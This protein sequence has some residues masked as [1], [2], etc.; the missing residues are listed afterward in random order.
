MT[1]GTRTN[2][3][4]GAGT[5]RGRRTPKR[6]FPFLAA[7][8]SVGW[9]VDVMLE[10]P[11]RREIVVLASSDSDCRPTVAD[12]NWSSSRKA[13]I[14]ETG[15]VSRRI[16]AQPVVDICLGL[17]FER[18]K[19]WRCRIRNC[20]FRQR[21]GGGLRASSHFISVGYDCCDRAE[22]VYQ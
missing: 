7:I 14:R 13:E 8:N 10:D 6:V 15:R 9:W 5:Y 3:V 1:L 12:M 21:C 11:R 17:L 4:S 2:V 19:N 22:N 16:G 18:R 20:M